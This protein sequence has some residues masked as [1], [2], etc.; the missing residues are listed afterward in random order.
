MPIV[1][2]IFSALMWIYRVFSLYAFWGLISFV[3]S[4]VVRFV[5]S[6][7]GFLSK[8]ILI[9]LIIIPIIV[10]SVVAILL[11]IK[12]SAESLAVVSPPHFNQAM[13]MIIPSNFH[14]VLNI[15]FGTEVALWVW[16]WQMK[17]I[18]MYIK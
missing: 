15:V 10:A 17:F 14:T 1:L 4:F 16:R 11:L 9:T 3:A 5:L 12:T 8:R 18:E 2:W 7:L 6:I 13:S